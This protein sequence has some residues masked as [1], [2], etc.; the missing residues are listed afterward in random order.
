MQLNNKIN[1]LKLSSILFTGFYQFYFI[2]NYNLDVLSKVK[3]PLIIQFHVIHVHTT[4]STHKHHTHTSPHLQTNTRYNVHI[5]KH[6]YSKIYVFSGECLL[7]KY[8]LHIS[9]QK[10][11]KIQNIKKFNMCN[12]HIL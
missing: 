5:P 9:F 4:P 3:I 2:L 8:N 10:K 1:D 6:P 7:M 12:V 11:M